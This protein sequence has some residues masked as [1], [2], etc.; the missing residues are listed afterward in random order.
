MDAQMR[1]EIEQ[2]SNSVAEAFLEVLIYADPYPGCDL[3]LAE[4]HIDAATLAFREMLCEHVGTELY[5]TDELSSTQSD[6]H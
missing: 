5:R 4:E 6:P 2:I 3:R 1:Q